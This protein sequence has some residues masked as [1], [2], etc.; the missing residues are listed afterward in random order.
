MATMAQVM[1]NHQEADPVFGP[2]FSALHT[3][4]DR[5]IEE[6]YYDTPELPHPVIAMEKDRSGRV[7]YYTVKDGYTLIHRIN[8]DPWKLRNGEEAAEVVAHELIHL[9][10]QYVG[11][12]IK[13]NYHSAEFHSRMALYGIQ[14]AGKAGKHTGYTTGRWQAWMEE[15]EDLQ[16]GMFQLPGMDKQQPNRPGLMKHLCVGCRASFRSRKE[17]KVKC[18]PCNIQFQVVKDKP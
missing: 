7:G 16:L 9:W 1:R 11:R 8:V 17:L 15:N 10:Q 6:F 3:F 5:T 13:R 2:L 12:P 4:V 14:T 18:I